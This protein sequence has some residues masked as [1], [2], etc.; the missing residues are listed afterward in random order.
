MVR[1]L[2]FI[3]SQEYY[4]LPKKNIRVHG[5]K[6]HIFIPNKFRDDQNLYQDKESIDLKLNEFKKRTLTCWNE[7]YQLLTV[8]TTKN[9]Q[10]RHY[11]LRLTSI[12]VP[13]RSPL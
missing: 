11:R 10:G 13:E 3:I 4:K 5:K 6:D 7:K 2:F 1:Y 9:K 8:Y 12:F